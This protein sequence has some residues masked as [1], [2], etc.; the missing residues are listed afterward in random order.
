MQNFI[1]LLQIFRLN[2]MNYSEV[3]NQTGDWRWPGQ[4]FEETGLAEG[5]LFRFSFFSSVLSS[6]AVNIM[7]DAP[8]SQSHAPIAL[9]PGIF[10]LEHCIYFI[11]LLECV[12]LERKTSFSSPHSFCYC[13]F[14]FCNRKFYLLNFQKM[15]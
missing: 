14:I 9:V 13:N 1:N 10:S 8:R 3:I 5:H 4:S 6:L 2:W 7:L 12:R 11:A 15:R